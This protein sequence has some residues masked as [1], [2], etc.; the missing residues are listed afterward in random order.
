MEITYG[1]KTET[2]W[3]VQRIRRKFYYAWIISGM[4]ETS[5]KLQLRLF[6]ICGFG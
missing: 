3:R 4:R 1:I 5:L 6:R 2:F